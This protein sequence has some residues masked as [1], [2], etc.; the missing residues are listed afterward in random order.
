MMD[1][2]IM[3][4]LSYCAGL[5]EANGNIY[6]RLDKYGR[7][8]IELTVYAKAPSPLHIFQDFFGGVG[9]IST[10]R[11]GKNHTYECRIHKIGEIQNIID[12]LR[13]LLSEFRRERARIGI[14]KFKNN[15]RGKS[16]QRKLTIEQ[17]KEIK[18]RLSIKDYQSHE[19][20]AADFGVSRAAIGH[21][22]QGKTYSYVNID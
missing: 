11:I 2:P 10:P 7:P 19:T 22:A 18:K 5:Y 15:P 16:Y 6:T 8:H 20:L 13:P 3:D 4:T 21:I 9:R 1:T 12:T 14:E 17:V